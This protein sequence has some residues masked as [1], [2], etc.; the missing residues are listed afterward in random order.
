MNFLGSVDNLGRCLV[1]LET[2]DSNSILLQVDTGFN[3]K[4]LITTYALPMLEDS[5]YLFIEGEGV[6][7]QLADLSEQIADYYSLKLLWFGNEEKIEAL[8]TT[9]IP[10]QAPK[11]DDPV[12]LIGT[13]MLLGC[14]LHIDF[15]SK[16]VEIIR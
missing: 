2:Q 10:K 5:N 3:G 9:H 4:I 7:I 14:K 12:G 1:R 16:E 11:E 8:L 6:K 15:P 13:G